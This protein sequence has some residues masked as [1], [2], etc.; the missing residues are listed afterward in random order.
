MSDSDNKTNLLENIKTVPSEVDPSEIEAVLSNKEL[1]E[2]ILREKGITNSTIHK[3]TIN[4]EAAYAVALFLVFFILG[5]FITSPFLQLV[6]RISSDVFDY[7]W[8]AGASESKDFIRFYDSYHNMIKGINWL[9]YLAVAFLYI[10]WIWRIITDRKSIHIHLK[11]TCIKLLPFFIFLLFDIGIVLVTIIRGPNEYDLNGHPYMNESIFSYI[12]YPIS[13]FFCGMMVYQA[14]RKKILLYSLVISAL[15]VNLIALMVE[16]GLPFPYYMKYGVIAV[17]HNSNHYGYYLAFVTMV[18]ALMF[19]Y[20]VKPVLKILLLFSMSLSTTMIVINNT[21]GA[22]LATGFV[23][24]LFF[25]YRLRDKNSK[26]SDDRNGSW[27]SALFVLILFVVITLFMSIG[28]QTV[29]KSLIKLFSD[30]GDIVNDFNT[31]DR[32]GSGRWKLWKN[33]VL[34]IPERPLTGFG[35]EGLLN[36]YMVGTPHNELLQYAAFFGIPVAVLYVSACVVT[37]VRV[38]R[39]RAKMSPIAMVC[40]FTAIGYLVNSLFGVAIYYTTPFLYIFLGLSY[41][42]CVKSDKDTD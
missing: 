25:I 35:V 41:S 29:T 9:V 8:S 17:F 6:M 20:E 7:E 30:T 38:W 18:S 28:Y 12:L 31:A 10:Y 24:T 40:F 1:T 26:K 16:Y 11:S 14:R 23:L 42:E 2:R 37:L 33:T 19:V 34:H 32:A 27:Q 22:F 15:P 3:S 4:K 13:Y 39:S 21:L 36:T 5:I